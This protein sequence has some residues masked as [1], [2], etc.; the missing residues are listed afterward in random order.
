[1]SAVSPVT[2]RTPL[3]PIEC[4]VSGSGPALLALHGGLGGCDQSLLLARALLGDAG[5]FRVV[6]VSRPGY[7]GTPLAVGATPEA[8]ADAYAALLD[9]LG[10][11]AAWV[12]AVSAGG[13]SA[14]AFARRH[15][16]RC[17]GL[18]LVSAATGRLEVPPH[19]LARLAT[20]RVLAHI[21]G[22]P[23]LLRRKL[24]RNQAAAAQRSIK[25]P[26]LARRTLAHPAAGP[27]LAELQAS[28]LDRLS[29]RLPGTARDTAFL[30]SLADAPF[31]PL[32]VPALVIHGTGDP[33]VSFAHAERVAASA[34]A[35]LLALE[36]GEHLVLFTHLD[37]VRVAAAEFLGTPRG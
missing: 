3:G 30:Q 16:G 22:I 20:M 7:L 21:P 28:V 32:P 15:A 19:V 6:A 26:E 11:E 18:I 10:I 37:T 13:P 27:L 12:A 31:E 8:Q 25:D 5:A 33:V 1:M 2:I 4:G 35:R 36:G 9:T 14:I 29:S 23:A 34:G 17:R 24:T